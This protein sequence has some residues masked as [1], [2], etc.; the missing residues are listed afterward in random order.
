MK[1]LVKRKLTQLFSIVKK[2]PSLRAVDRKSAMFLFF[3]FA[4]AGV[5]LLVEPTYGIADGAV[6]AAVEG[7]GN[8]IGQWITEAFMGMSAF[9]IKMA[10]FFLQ[11]FIAIAGWNNYLDVPTVMLGWTMVRDVANMFFVVILLVIA[12]GTILG[13]EQYQ[14]NKTLVKLILAAVFINFSNLICGIFI[15]AAHVFTITFV[16]AVSATAGGNFIQAFNLQE[17]FKLVSDPTASKTD[18]AS[19]FS[20]NLFVAALA[21]L[22]FSITAMCIVAVYAIIMLARMVALWVLVILSPLAFIFQVLPGTQSYAKQWWDKFMKQVLVAPVMVFFLWLTFATVGTGGVSDDIG[23]KITQE[24]DGKLVTVASSL[25]KATEWGSMASFFIPLA[26]MIV[27]VNVVTQL[28]VVGGG[29]AQS[30]L[31]VAKKIGGYAS[32]WNAT[33]WTARKGW[34]GSKAVAMAPVKVAGLLAKKTV[35]EPITDILKTEKAGAVKWFYDQA[36]QGSGPIAWYARNTV[37]RRKRLGKTEDMAKIMENLAFTRN[38]AGSGGRIFGKQKDTVM[39][40][41]VK[42][43]KRVMEGVLE[44]EKARKAAKDKRYMADGKKMVA[45]RQRFK[46]G[47][48][49]EGKTIQEEIEDHL[50]KA[51]ITEGQLEKISGDIKVRILRDDSEGSSAD[52]LASVLSDVE[53]NNEQIQGWEQSAMYG[54]LRDKY[55]ADKNKID[56]AA[57]GNSTISE[58][59]ERQGILGEE[60]EKAQK[61][62]EGSQNE[63]MA[64][65]DGMN[66][67]DDVK[68]G[69]RE[70]WKVAREV[71]FKV[72]RE[73]GQ[74]DDEHSANVMAAINKSFEEQVDG[75]KDKFTDSQRM[76]IENKFLDDETQKKVGSIVESKTA[77]ES[78]SKKLDEEKKIVAGEKQKIVEDLSA[79]GEVP[80]WEASRA[81]ALREHNSTF[82]RSARKTLLSDAAQSEIWD[83]HGIV[84]PNDGEEEAIEATVQ[85]FKDMNYEMTLAGYQG[86]KKKIREKRERGEE[87]NFEDK[88]VGMALHR[89]LFSGAWIDDKIPMIEDDVDQYFK[90]LSGGDQ[91]SPEFERLKR[92]VQKPAGGATVMTEDVATNMKKILNNVFENEKSALSG[93]FEGIEKGM[94]ITTLKSKFASLLNSKM[95]GLDIN[96][97]KS[98]FGS[99]AKADDASGKANQVIDILKGL[100]ATDTKRFEELK[101]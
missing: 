83:K 74:S 97:L 56:N 40:Q 33:K 57:A 6:G 49:Q 101:K 1:T 38:S 75:M 27:G 65:I 18:A 5:V 96:V 60:I 10:I 62:Y 64:V 77:I 71:G 95:S 48:F 37:K 4:V 53:M 58:S 52:R 19:N 42:D 23:L 12:F 82:Y 91:K 69:F 8:S 86:H 2:V 20:I 88:V 87:V 50:I 34:E 45:E 59:N 100:H 92:I 81:Q 98:V 39:G 36:A 32:G 25:S 35:V 73:D 17:L 85:S 76:R 29:L 7:V 94:D 46:N 70:A 90:D 89:K 63:M 44:Q 13:V 84:T 21:S 61:I 16:N 3:V 24:G 11:Y 22:L 79:R 47:K 14:W 9:A 30:G 43:E 26:L 51:R 41:K 99:D 68:D 78:K 15:D 80:A 28:G 93:I 67:G 55:A 66:V 72:K 54:K 31:N